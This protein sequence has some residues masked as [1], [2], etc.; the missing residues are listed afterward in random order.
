[1]GSRFTL[2]VIEGLLRVTIQIGKMGI[3]MENG[4]DF[5]GEAAIL[6]EKY[7]ILHKSLGDIPH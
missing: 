3:C 4:V 6:G 7:L 2:Q 5:S 1:M